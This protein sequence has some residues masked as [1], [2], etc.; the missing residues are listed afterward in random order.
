[1][2]IRDVASE[3]TIAEGRWKTVDEGITA[4]KYQFPMKVNI[5]HIDT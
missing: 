5:R 1:M 4:K 3:K 2:F